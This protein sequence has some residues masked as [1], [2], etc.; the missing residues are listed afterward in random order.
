MI[1]QNRGLRQQLAVDEGSLDGVSDRDEHAVMAAIGLLGRRQR[2]D[3]LRCL[4]DEL[5]RGLGVARHPRM[6]E[7]IELRRRI[8][9]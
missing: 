9:Q 8:Q 6:P 3:R 2:L 7:R 4:D 5:G 1:R